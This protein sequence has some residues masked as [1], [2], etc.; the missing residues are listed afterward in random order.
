MK[1][2]KIA[3]PFTDEYC[4]NEIK[5]YGVMEYNKGDVEIVPK[6]M[7]GRCDDYLN[8]NF[9][10]CDFEMPVL[11]IKGQLFMSLSFMEV[12][13]HYLPI[14]LAEGEVMCGGLGIGYFVNS[15]MPYGTVA[16]IDVYEINKDV[17]KFF[18][19][20]FQHKEGFEKV[21]FI[22]EDIR[23]VKGK[24]YNFAFVDIYPDMDF[25]VIISDLE[26][27]TRNNTILDYH[28]W[29]QE[30]LRFEAL[31]DD[32]ISIDDLPY[33]ERL[34]YK[35]WFETDLHNMWQGICDNELI[36]RYLEYVGLG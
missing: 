19:D 16:S 24:E 15:I 4:K 3:N 1:T 36:E 13:S 31:N 35:M 8:K 25:E 28:A 10:V 32:L 12:Q 9:R 30:K 27:L 7:N 2:E 26:L 21:K 29:G 14:Q 23:N 17:I 22:N 5:N 34:Y 33:A 20:K 11:F 18:Q 6:K